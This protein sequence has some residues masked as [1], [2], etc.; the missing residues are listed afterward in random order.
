MNFYI[1]ES[2]NTGDLSRTSA[3]LDFGGQ[4]VF[5][6]AAI[7]I[8]DES[9]L[10]DKLNVLREK[11]NVKSDELKLSK[12]L[13]RKP[14]FAL[15]AV[16]LIAQERF[17]FF[18]EIVDK[19]YQ[20]AVSIT[21]GF[22][23]SPYFNTEESQGTVWLKNIFADYIYHNVPNEIF[24]RFIQ[25]MDKPSNE[26]TREFFDLLRDCISSRS[27]DVAQGIV[28]QVEE[29]KNDFRL[30][31]EREGHNAYKW[32]LPLPD[33]GKRDQ[34]VWLLPNFASFT[35]IYARINLFLSR[36]LTGCKIIHDE[37]AHFDEIIEMA[38]MQVESA[39][40]KE[41]SYK[42]PFADYDIKQAAS[43]IFRASPES[44]G[45]QFADIVAGLSMRWYLARLQ[46]EAIPEVLVQAI[47]IL[48][49]HSDRKK[50]IGINMVAP[51]NMAEQLFG[52]SGY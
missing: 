10:T 15:E 47:N 22:I 7:G 3:N 37:Q 52:V 6:L 28:S 40:I 19:R 8:S 23:W 1:D 49:G 26:K 36:N 38:K 34:E 5:S 2:G 13:K 39:D 4:P 11:H 48:L 24:F 17:P 45:I 35:N 46:G 12:I 9:N 18:I 50:G 42:P 25:C 32:F 43:L 51:H 20:L 30:M 29:S 33:S 21:N 41:F 16:E 27:H 14:D 44:T 31:I